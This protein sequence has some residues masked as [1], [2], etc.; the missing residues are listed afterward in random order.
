MGATGANFPHSAI[1]CGISA[2]SRA[3]RPKATAQ[4]VELSLHVQRQG[5]VIWPTTS[6][7][8]EDRQKQVGEWGIF[9]SKLR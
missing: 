8:L 7:N 3:L 6:V 4:D 9:Y 2:K 5:T 1:F